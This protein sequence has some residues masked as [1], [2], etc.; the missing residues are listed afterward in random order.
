MASTARMATAVMFVAAVLL[1]QCC[2]VIVATR[3]LEGD[4]GWLRLGQDSGSLIMQQSTVLPSASVTESPR[5]ESWTRREDAVGTSRLADQTGVPVGACTPAACSARC[6][7]PCRGWRSR[8][9]CRSARAESWT[10]RE[11]VVGASR[12]A[13]GGVRSGVNQR[14]SGYS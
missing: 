3:L 5:A 14:V 6:L 9:A 11:E 10:R 7:N 12:V 8:P 1:M 2:N 4:G 13:V